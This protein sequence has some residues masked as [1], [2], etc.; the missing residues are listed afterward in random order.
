MLPLT[1]KLLFYL[2]LVL[3]ESEKATQ[4]ILSEPQTHYYI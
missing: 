3:F 4:I 2:E 1:T